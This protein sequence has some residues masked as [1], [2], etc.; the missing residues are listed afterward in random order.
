MMA[1]SF[2]YSQ[3]EGM[4]ECLLEHYSTLQLFV[5]EQVSIT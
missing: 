4:R 2:N 3:R 1:N 5:E